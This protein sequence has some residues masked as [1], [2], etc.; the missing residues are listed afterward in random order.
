LKSTVQ[1]TLRQDE[2]RNNGQSLPRKPRGKS[3]TDSEE[4]LLLRHV[5]LNPKDTY[6]QVIA[7]CN[8]SYKP[9]TVKKIL[10]KHSICNWRAKKRPELTEA[11]ALTRLAWC[12]VREGWTAEEWGL[13]YWSDE[14]SVERGRDKRGEWYFRTS[15]QKWNKEMVQTYSISKN[16]KIMV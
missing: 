1:Y 13:V 12:L 2:L 15:A 3:Y 8:L 11:H 4:R 9:T 16:M 14:Y 5:R 10:K 7:A 6:K